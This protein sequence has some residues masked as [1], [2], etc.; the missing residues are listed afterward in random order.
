MIY[1]LIKDDIVLNCDNDKDKDSAVQDGFRVLSDAEIQ[2][3]GLSGYEHLASPATVTVHQNGSITFAAP[4][5]SS[6]QREKILMDIAALEALETPRR[7]REAL[8]TD[9]GRAWLKANDDAIA[10]KRAEISAI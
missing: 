7:M 2:S 10:T 9:A 3:A 4:S 1:V 5:A 6:L 8:L